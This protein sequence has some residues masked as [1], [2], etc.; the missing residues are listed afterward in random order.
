MCFDAASDQLSKEHRA[1]KK[2]NRHHDDYKITRGDLTEQ[3]KTRADSA[4]KGVDKLKQICLDISAVLKWPMPALEEDNAAESFA[5][6]IVDPL[7]LLNQ[8][9][10]VDWTK[11][12]WDDDEMCR[13]YTDIPDLKNI[14]PLA[15]LTAYETES[16]KKKKKP[17]KRAVD[18]DAFDDAW[19]DNIDDEFLDSIERA[20]EAN[21][22]V[23]GVDA[24]K[25]TH[26]AQL[27]NLFLRLPNLINRELIDE[28]AVEFAQVTLPFCTLSC[29]LDSIP[30]LDPC[31]SATSAAFCH[32]LA[33]SFRFVA[34]LLS[35]D[36]DSPSIHARHQR[37]G[38]NRFSLGIPSP[39]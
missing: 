3:Q 31:A 6:T 7:S 22:E 19:F 14:V 12:P 1:L 21:E 36:R 8:S 15:I 17:R 16:K 18:D 11:T 33:L 28:A 2:I 34:L 5:A 30:R 26:H 32:R 4:A 25:P 24:L 23:D 27:D 20:A 38:H 37:H 39:L 29:D 10:D 35:S 13:F 9:A